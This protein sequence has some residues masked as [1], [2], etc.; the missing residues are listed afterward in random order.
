MS[1]TTNLQLE[2]PDKDDYYDIQVQNANMD[3]I[4]TAINNLSNDKAEKTVVEELKKSVSDGKTLV[5]NAI[6]DKGVSTSK[7]AT[8]Q[9]MATNISKIT[10]GVDTSD[11]TATA[12][13][14]ISGKTAYVKGSKVAGSI[15]NYTDNDVMAMSVNCYEPEIW[16]R[17]QAGY[18]GE[19][20]TQIYWPE[21]NLTASNIVK[22]ATILGISGTGGL[23][24]TSSLSSYWPEDYPENIMFYQ[25]GTSYSL[26]KLPQLQLGINFI[27]SVVKISFTVGATNY[28]AVIHKDSRSICYEKSGASDVSVVRAWAYYNEWIKPLNAEQKKVNLFC[29]DKLGASTVTDIYYEAWE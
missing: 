3:K 21:P 6:T 4:D 9:T 20:I 5:A 11:A 17:P 18:Y 1:T 10:T 27:P 14:I 25:D 24:H 8:F 28:I 7:D 23:Q 26:A 16:I 13:D 12:K 2:K 29:I 19:G 15:Q 22:G